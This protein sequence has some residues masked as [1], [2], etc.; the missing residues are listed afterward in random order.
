MDVEGSAP[1]V[2]PGIK[3]S[4]LPEEDDAVL[5]PELATKFRRVVARANFLAQD[6]MDIQFATKEAARGMATPRQSHYDKLI[7]LAK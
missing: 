2:T 7:R 1:V 5:K 6:R 3:A 4:P